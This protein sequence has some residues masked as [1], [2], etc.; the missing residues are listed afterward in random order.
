MNKIKPI[1]FNISKGKYF[2]D[3]S[4]D[5]NG[6]EAAYVG[7][8]SVWENPYKVKMSKDGFYHIWLSEKIRSIRTIEIAEAIVKESYKSF[9]DAQKDS[10][11][12][13]AKLLFPYEHK[14]SDLTDFFISKANLESVEK[15]L[16]GKNLAVR[17]N[18]KINFH[19]DYLLEIAN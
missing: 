7:S 2:M 11:M 12:C 10:L 18:F 16:K 1:V 19:A 14:N 17:G 13:Y 15:E 5:I 6:L 9:D 8:G 3:V 4:L